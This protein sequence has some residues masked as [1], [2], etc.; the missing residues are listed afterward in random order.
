MLIYNIYSN[1]NFGGVKLDNSI[2]LNNVIKQFKGFELGPIDLKIKKGYITGFIGANGSGKTT[3]IKAIMD[4]ISID[5]GDIQIFGKNMKKEPVFIKNRIGFLYDEV[6]YYEMIKVKHMGEIAATFYEN[7]SWENFE[8]YLKKFNINGNEKISNLSRGTKVKFSLAIAL[9][10]NADLFIFDE[11]MNGLDPL[12]RDEIM[13]IF[14][15]IVTD[16]NKTIFLSSHITEDLEKIADNIIFI[17]N[18]KVLISGN[19]DEILSEH[20]LVKGENKEDFDFFNEKIINKEIK[21]YGVEALCKISEYE[22]KNTSDKL[23]YDKAS[24]KDIMIGYV[25]GGKLL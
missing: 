2:V 19:K 18:G 12:A 6:G 5:S 17:D 3:T 14:Q 8:S 20:F 4:L 21:K 9:S 23:I 16:E 7:W 1:N 11:P 15:S 22:F 25:K 10:H 24:L 13:D